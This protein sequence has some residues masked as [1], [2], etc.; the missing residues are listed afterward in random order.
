LP[1]QIFYG[2]QP[3]T[4]EFKVEVN[5]P[6]RIGAIYIFL[7]LQDKSTNELTAWGSSRAM[8]YTSDRITYT[9][10]YS[11]AS[12]ENYNKYDD[13]FLLYQY[14]AVDPQQNVIGRSQVFKEISLSRCGA[15]PVPVDVTPTVWFIEFDPDELLP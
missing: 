13:S 5:Q 7:R 15:A 4:I 8:N 1:Y 6:E 2:C 10:K 11:S 9:Q 12:I 14:V 3:D